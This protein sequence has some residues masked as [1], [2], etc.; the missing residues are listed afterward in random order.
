MKRMVF[1]IVLIVIRKNKFVVRIHIKQNNSTYTTNTLTLI[2]TDTSSDADT[3]THTH[4]RANSFT[5]T[6][7][8]MQTL[9]HRHPCKLTNTDTQSH[10]N[11][12]HTD[13]HSELIK[14]PMPS[15]SRDTSVMV[16]AD[17][18]FWLVQNLKMAQLPRG[19]VSSA[20]ICGST[21]IMQT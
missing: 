1:R 13:T 14:T 10:I 2:Q 12:N 18:R 7:N 17:A 11:H 21:A 3:I 4:T 15:S 16:T 9:S 19:F 6:L 5:H 20:S 8:H